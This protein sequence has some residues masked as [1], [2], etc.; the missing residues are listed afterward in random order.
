MAAGLPEESL[1]LLLRMSGGQCAT[2]EA[3]EGQDPEGEHEVRVL[4][5]D[6][7]T[8]MQQPPHRDAERD[9]EAAEKAP[10]RLPELGET[11]GAEEGGDPPA[12]RIACE[13]RRNFDEVGHDAR[14]E[15][16]AGATAGLPVEERFRDSHRKT[17]EIRRLGFRLAIRR[18]STRRSELADQNANLAPRLASS[19]KAGVN[20]AA[21][22][23]LR[24]MRAWS[25]PP[26]LLL[27]RPMLK[28]VVMKDLIFAAVTVAFFGVSWLYAK[29]FDRL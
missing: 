14:D 27:A 11:L 15:C 8:A 16:I 5:G 10:P 22:T 28:K 29:S 17:Q 20:P 2:H 25:W 13:R 12:A 24:C 26:G 21:N 7:E 3:E 9:D 4:T 19:G 6:A 18:R 1:D 23:Q